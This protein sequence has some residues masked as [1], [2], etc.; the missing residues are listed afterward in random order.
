MSTILASGAIQMNEKDKTEVNKTE[1]SKNS[2]NRN[3]LDYMETKK[4]EI[5]KE[6]KLNKN[7]WEGE[8]VKNIE[9][10]IKLEYS[11][12][13]GSNFRRWEKKLEYFMET[14]GKNEEIISIRD[15]KLEIN[16][17]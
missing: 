11:T 7:N 1:T 8:W 15:E 9:E 13:Q 16:L 10:R 2:G 14:W 12:T 3:T 17:P 5:F 4:R 6:I